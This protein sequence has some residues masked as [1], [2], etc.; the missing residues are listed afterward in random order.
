MT[1]YINTQTM[2]YPISQQ[3]IQK[4]YSNTS[5]SSPFVAPYPYMQV[6]ATTAP[7]YNAITQL[8]QETTPTEKLTQWYQTWEII[9]LNPEQIAINEQNQAQVNKQQAVSLL[10]QTDWSSIADVADSEKSNPYLINQAEFIAY[11]SQLRQIAVYP[12]WDAVFPKEPVEVWS[13]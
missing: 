8:A 10:Q 12:T 9:E 4:E 5:F 13:S 7:A 2:A 3:Q 6:I 11:R 1:N